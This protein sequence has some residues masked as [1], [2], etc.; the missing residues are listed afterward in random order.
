M[1]HPTVVVQQ[2]VLSGK[3]GENIHGDKFYSFQGIPYAKPPLGKL[4]FKVIFYFSFYNI[5]IHS[6]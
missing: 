2:G 4:R 5:I 3:I 6:F 1:A